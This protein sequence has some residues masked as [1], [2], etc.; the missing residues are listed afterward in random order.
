M[1]KNISLLPSWYGFY[2]VS[3]SLCKTELGANQ[4]KLGLSEPGKKQA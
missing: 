1:G 2:T 4:R 3:F